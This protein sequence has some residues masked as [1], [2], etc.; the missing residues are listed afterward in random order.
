MSSS[1][2]AERGATERIDPS[3]GGGGQVLA[4]VIIQ[5][6]PRDIVVEK[7]ILLAVIKGSKGHFGEISSCAVYAL[8]FADN[9]RHK[10]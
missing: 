7:Y 6:G 3:R 10:H 1:P 9:H 8:G 5:V 4:V 2:D